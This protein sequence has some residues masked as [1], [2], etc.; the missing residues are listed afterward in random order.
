MLPSFVHL[1]VK[2]SRSPWLAHL[3]LLVVTLLCSA[4]MVLVHQGFLS[5]DKG[6]EG[7]TL[8]GLLKTKQVADGHQDAFK[9][10][11]A[12]GFMKA[13][14]MTQRTQGGRTLTHVEQPCFYH[15]Y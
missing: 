10:G 5:R 1:D 7:E 4:L 8:E 13:Q 15:V 3:V 2:P 9:S 11:F 6:L 12:E 14:A